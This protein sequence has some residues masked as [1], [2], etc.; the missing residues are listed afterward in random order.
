MIGSSGRVG[1]VSALLTAVAL[2]AGGCG[3]VDGGLRGIPLPG[4]AN[5]GDDPYSVQIEFADVVDLV[6]QSIVRVGDVPVAAVARPR[7]RR[8]SGPCRCCSTAV[9]W[10]R[11]GPSPPS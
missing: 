11:S 9:A 1:R 7:S 10:P 3:A 8:S 4:G 2:F 5:L 6:P